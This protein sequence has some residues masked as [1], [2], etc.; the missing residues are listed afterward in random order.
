MEPL[1]HLKNRASEHWLIG[2][3][4][5]QFAQLTEQLYLELT[6]SHHTPPKVLLAEGNPVRFL[7]GFVAAC[8]AGCP[9][10]LGNPNW[11]EQEWQQVFRLVQPDLILGHGDWGSSVT[12]YYPSSQPKVLNPQWIMIPTGGSSG[13]IRFAIHTWKTLMASVQGF[14]QYFQ[15]QRVN[16]FCTLPLH[17]VSGLMQFLRSFTTGGQLA[18]VTLKELTTAQPT[19]GSLCAFAPLQEQSIAAVDPSDFFISLVPT[20]LQRLLQPDTVTWLSRFQT[21][22]VGGAPTW[23]ELLEQARSHNIRLSLTYGMTETASQI[24][25]L[26]PEAFLSGAVSCGQSYPMLE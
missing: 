5:C 13:H 2:H 3:D 12:A 24:V 23:P 16:S 22:L 14:K 6:Q 25:T 18:I 4:S 21:V 10:F 19:S 11:V 26:K 20:Q 17:H 8:A 15:L 1:D 7:A 9:V